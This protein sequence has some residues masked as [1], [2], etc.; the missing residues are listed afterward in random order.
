L[1]V[2]AI[3][4]IYWQVSGY[5]FLTY[6]DRNYVT[7]NPMVLEGLSWQGLKWAMTATFDA[8]WFPVTWLSHMLDVQLFGTRPAGH[9]LVNVVIHGVNALILFAT[10]TRMTGKPWRSAAVTLI[11]A[12]HPLR[13]E[14]VAWVA[15]RKDVLSAFFGLLT[16]HAYARYVERPGTGRYLTVL[17]LFVLGLMTKPM[18]VTLPFLLLLLDFWPLCRPGGAIPVRRAVLEKLPLLLPAILSCVITYLVQNQGGAVND[19]NSSTFPVNLANALVSYVVY[20]RQFFWPANLSVMYPFAD[21]LPIWQP[22]AAAGLLAAVSLAAVKLSARRPWLATGWFWYLGTMVPV[23]G[24]VRIGIHAHADRYTYLPLIGAA[25][26]VVW[27]VADL[28]MG[29]RY[30]RAM[31]AGALLLVVAACTITTLGQLRYWTDTITLFRRALAVTDNNWLAQNNLAAELVKQG[32]YHEGER[33]LREAIRI[34]PDYASAYT[35]LGI[36]YMM[37][38]EREQAMEAYRTAIYHN[39]KEEIAIR[40]LGF[41]LANSGDLAAAFAEYQRL[42]PINPTQAEM[43]L[44][45][46]EQLSGRQ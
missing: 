24:V 36:V 2:T 43:L 9:H 41:A 14:S 33:H 39:P 27:G 28:A 40:N 19:L 23:I 11:F 30:G 6:D 20:L 5:Q 26:I 22:L 37:K 21:S 34:K 35:N 17:L 18:L 32:D 10:L 1:L 31:V 38:R 45:L 42:L 8:N 29:W 7:E 44:K 46:L 12:L 3:T 16:L 13:V 25:I 4:A 15:E